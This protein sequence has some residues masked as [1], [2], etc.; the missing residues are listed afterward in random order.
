VRMRLANLGI[1]C[2]FPAELAFNAPVHK[3]EEDLRLA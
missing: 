2:H 1:E 3:Q